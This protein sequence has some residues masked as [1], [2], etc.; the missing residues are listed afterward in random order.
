M[1]E[2]IKMAGLPA[3]FTCSECD[4]K[5]HSDKF[6]RRFMEDTR[7]RSRY[8]GHLCPNC[9]RKYNDQRRQE[10]ERKIQIQAELRI[11]EVE[12]QKKSKEQEAEARKTEAECRVKEKEE[13][14][15]KLRLQNEAKK[16]ELEMTISQN[17]KE[18]TLALIE[19]FNDPEQLVKALGS[20]I[21]RSPDDKV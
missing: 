19:K 13:E 1:V 11:Q 8:K 7:F 17:S 14:T 18:I 2:S 12:L 21:S 3:K 15:K 5:F 4:N 10:E 16:K 9:E 6:K 20:I